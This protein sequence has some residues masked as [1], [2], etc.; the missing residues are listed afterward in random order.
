MNPIGPGQ[1]GASSRDLID[2]NAPMPLYFQLKQ[3][4][5]RHIKENALKPGDRLP[6]GDEIVQL[7]GVSHATIRQALN[8]MV[9][10]GIIERI[11]GKG[12]FVAT[13][14]IHHRPF[15]TSFSEN[16]RSQGYRPS[17]QLLRSELVEIPPDVAAKIGLPE[18]TPA[19]YLRRL[20]L[21]D[22]VTIGLADSWLP[23]EVLAGHDDLLDAG[24]MA[25]ASLYD[26]LQAPPL[27]LELQRG[28]ETITPAV[29]TPDHHKL[30]ACEPGTPVLRVER[31]TYTRGDQLIEFT[32]TTYDGTRYE[33]RV[34]M[35][36]PSGESSARREAQSIADA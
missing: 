13:P 18:G 6:T 14:K 1:A 7:Y 16:M 34:E 26:V 36:P 24:H 15:L 20:L 8:E 17:R 29:A 31:V 3:A 35:F 25:D 30:L 5:L 33:Y 23:V 9:A 19:R 12:T 2:R 22:D 28:I 11:Q 27:Q 4:L 32:Q 10:E 21:A